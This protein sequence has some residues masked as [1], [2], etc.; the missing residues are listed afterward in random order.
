M[1]AFITIPYPDRVE[2]LTDGACTDPD[3]IFL[4]NQTKVWVAPDLPLAITGVGAMSEIG[5]LVDITME[6]CRFGSVD[7][8]IRLLKD[9]FERFGPVECERGFRI[10]IACH[11]EIWGASLWSYTNH[12][13]GTGST[14][15]YRLSLCAGLEAMGP[16]L[17][18]NDIEA[19]GLPEN[20]FA[21]GLLPHG[22]SLMEA[23]RSKP[24]RSPS[25]PEM[26][27]GFYIGGHIDWTVVSADGVTVERVREWPDRIGEKI[28]PERRM[29]TR[30]EVRE[31]ACHRKETDSGVFT[32]H[33]G[34]VWRGEGGT[35]LVTDNT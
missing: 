23:M 9:G 28:D 33:D 8:A 17:K 19:V 13:Y 10:L 3:G 15:A 32:S 30:G 7:T 2:L 6:A 31:I 24:G 12:D 18:M 4:R 35:I 16:G 11:S 26:E 25:D 29:P 20:P 27:P 5:P 14:P 1:S 21:S 34:H 22:I